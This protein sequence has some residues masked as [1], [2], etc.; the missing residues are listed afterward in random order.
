MKNKAM[1]MGRQ[2]FTLVELLVVIAIIGILSTLAIVSFGSV[3]AK[4]RDAERLNDMTVIRK[5]M[6]IIVTDQ[7]SYTAS[8]CDVYSSGGSTNG[9]VSDCAVASNLLDNYTHDLSA[10]NDPLNEMDNCCDKCSI[11]P[12]FVAGCNYCF[13]DIDDEYFEVMFVLENGF[14]GDAPG[15]YIADQNGIS[16]FELTGSYIT[17]GN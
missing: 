5:A 16:K 4:A 8:G 11:D 13:N 3:K 6:S 15:C 14:Q 17:L 9:F 7:N 12:D 10:I 1:P 2:A